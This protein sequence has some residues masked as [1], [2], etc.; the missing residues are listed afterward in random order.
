MV[1]ALNGLGVFKRINRFIPFRAGSKPPLHL[2]LVRA[3]IGLPL[4]FVCMDGQFLLLTEQKTGERIKAN[5]I[6]C[7]STPTK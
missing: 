1:T 3:Y 5:I 2:P 7:K 4:L 6:V